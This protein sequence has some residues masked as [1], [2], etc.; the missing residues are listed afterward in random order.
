MFGNLLV[1]HVGAVLVEAIDDVGD[2]PFV[3]GNEFGG[4][5]DR[6]P[7]LILIC[8]WVPADIRARADMGSP[9]LPVVTMMTSSSG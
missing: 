8:L 3:A 2:G 4:E 6:V 1:D 9:W 7:L 5:H